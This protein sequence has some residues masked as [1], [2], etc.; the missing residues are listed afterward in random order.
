MIVVVLVTMIVMVVKVVM[1]D[2]DGG[3]DVMIANDASFSS[4]STV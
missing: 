2:G 3:G 4:W 1:I